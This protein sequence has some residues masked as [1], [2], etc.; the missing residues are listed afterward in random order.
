VE[1]PSVWPHTCRVW[2]WHLIDAWRATSNSIQHLPGLLSRGLANP[3][4]CITRAV[5]IGS[6]GRWGAPRW[7]FLAALLAEAGCGEVGVQEGV[8]VV[9]GPLHAR[10][11]PAAVGQPGR[12]P[13]SAGVLLVPRAAGCVTVTGH[14]VA[15]EQLG[16]VVS[17]AMCEP[18]WLLPCPAHAHT[19]AGVVA[20]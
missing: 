10:G 9:H 5:L 20:R 14:G 8:E 18:L 1:E 13:L 16:L 4:P 17:R 15:G 2:V 3:G 11:V 7:R 19:P 12:A 6:R